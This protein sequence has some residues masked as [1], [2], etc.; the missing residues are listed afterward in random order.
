METARE[1]DPRERGQA[2]RWSRERTEIP[3]DGNEGLQVAAGRLGLDSGEGLGRA[4]MWSHRAGQCRCGACIWARGR[5]A[6]FCSERQK[7]GDAIDRTG[8]GTEV[9]RSVGTQLGPTLV[10][11]GLELNEKTDTQGNFLLFFFQ[12]LVRGSSRCGAVG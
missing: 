6:C 8:W 11:K 7:D 4:E 10:L 12:E 2:F 1:G 5:R 3:S 9:G